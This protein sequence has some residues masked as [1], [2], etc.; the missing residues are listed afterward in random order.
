M[1]TV[2]V[3]THCK[4][5]RGTPLA[6]PN[7]NHMAYSDFIHLI[8]LAGCPEIFSLTSRQFHYYL[9]ILHFLMYTQSWR[10]REDISCR[11]NVAS[12]GRDQGGKWGAWETWPG[13]VLLLSP[14]PP[15]FHLMPCRGS[16]AWN[17]SWNHN[18]QTQVCMQPWTRINASAQQAQSFVKRCHGKTKSLCQDASWVGNCLA[19][20]YALTRAIKISLS[21]QKIVPGSFFAR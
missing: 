5:W 19:V 7:T 8:F 20:W 21:S 4:S 11:E 18:K 13:T 17:P 9:S 2:S 16:C 12:G 14:Q 6:N 1:I 10:L 3:G 15:F